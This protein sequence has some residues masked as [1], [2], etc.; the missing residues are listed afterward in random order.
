MHYSEDFKKQ[1]LQLAEEIGVQEASQ[2][3]GIGS[4]TLYKWHR[5]SAGSEQAV[6]AVFVSSVPQTEKEPAEQTVPP[7]L[8]IDV[9]KELEEQ[10]ALNQAIQ[11]TVEY[12]IE[13]NT[14]LR[15]QCERYLH[16]ITLISQR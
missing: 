9:N 12:L 2:Q 7:E 15:Q 6:P 10:K 13:E 11:Q 3:L 16:A 4:S 8:T 14:A 5:I 1:A